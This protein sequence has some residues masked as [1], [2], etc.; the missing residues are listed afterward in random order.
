V[1]DTDIFG[2][3]SMA[4]ETGLCAGVVF[5]PFQETD[6]LDR[7]VERLARKAQAGAQFVVTQPAYDAAG[8]DLL[9]RATADC[10]LPVVMGILPVRT[11]RHADFLNDKVAGIVVPAAVRQRMHQAADPTAEGSANAR[12]VLT[13]ARERFA[14]ACIMPP[15]D[16]YEV[17]FDILPAASPGTAA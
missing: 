15:F 6:G 10:G 16:H 11:P 9:A 14:G 12:E 2:L 1:R 17:L 5:D 7:A 13:L 3:L 4:R 8:A